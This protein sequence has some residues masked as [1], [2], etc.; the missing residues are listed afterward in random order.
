LS[1]GSSYRYKQVI[2]VRGDIKLGRGKLAAQVAH[3]AIGGMLDA[4]KKKPEWLEEWL[5]EGQKKVVVKGGDEAHLLQLRRIAEDK[6]L[7]N[8][9]VRDAGLTQVEPNTL[10]V[11]ALGPAPEE[12]LDS[13]TGDLPLL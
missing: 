11:L 6:G 4:R 10:T 3:G 1:D 9:L 5:R 8:H 2:V 13:L 7:P 12:L